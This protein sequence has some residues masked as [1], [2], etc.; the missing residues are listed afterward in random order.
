MGALGWGHQRRNVWRA[1]LGKLAPTLKALKEKLGERLWVALLLLP[2]AQPGGFDP[3]ARAGSPDPQ[4]VCLALQ[5]CYELGLLADYL[6][7]GELDK[8][9]AYSQPIV[10]RAIIRSVCARFAS[11][12]AMVSS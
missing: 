3:G 9:E 4:L 8:I 7:G 1:N 6:D 2:A 11:S 5:K 10:D 12:T